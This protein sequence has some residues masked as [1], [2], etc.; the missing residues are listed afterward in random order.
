MREHT[1]AKGDVIIK[2]GD[3]G[4]VLY[5]VDSGKLH[6]HRKINKDDEHPGTF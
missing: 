3:D 5:C 1:F 2:Q 6:C 4:D